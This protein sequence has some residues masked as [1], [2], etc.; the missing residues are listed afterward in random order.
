M[1]GIVTFYVPPT[2]RINI[3][4]RNSWKEKAGHIF[5]CVIVSSFHFSISALEIH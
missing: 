1:K 4:N 5:L 3:Y 2:L